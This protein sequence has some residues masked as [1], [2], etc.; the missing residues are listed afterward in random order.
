MVIRVVV[1][2]A[3]CSLF[4]AIIVFA[5]ER[6]GFDVVFEDGLSLI[7]RDHLKRMGT[8]RAHARALHGFRHE[9]SAVCRAFRRSCFVVQRCFYKHVAC[10]TWSMPTLAYSYAKHSEHPYLQYKLKF[11]SRGRLELA[12][13]HPRS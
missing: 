3:A 10:A 9:P 11:N 5:V 13:Q 1:T 12:A 2:V 7:R 6:R 8:P 4:F